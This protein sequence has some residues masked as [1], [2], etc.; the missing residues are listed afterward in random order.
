ME[1]PHL[2]RNLLFLILITSLTGNTLNSV[3]ESCTLSLDFTLSVYAYSFRKWSVNFQVLHF[4]ADLVA[5]RRG[6]EEGKRNKEEVREGTAKMR[7]EG[8]CVGC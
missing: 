1:R 7:K 2:T 5:V 3:S 8:K 4:P 6:L